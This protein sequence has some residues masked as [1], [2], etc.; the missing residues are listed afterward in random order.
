M[1]LHPVHTTEGG[2]VHTPTVHKHCS[3][4]EPSLL[5]QLFTLL[6][7]NNTGGL[8]SSTDIKDGYYL[9]FGVTLE[10]KP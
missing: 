2:R 7:F 4:P 10:W 3:C 1:S 5:L 8:L 6:L 9:V